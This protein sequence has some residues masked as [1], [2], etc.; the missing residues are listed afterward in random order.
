M[1][2]D[3]LLGAYRRLRL[4]REFEERTRLEFQTGQIAGF[5]HL[6]AGMEAIAV[7]VCEHLSDEDKI[8]STHRGHGHCLAKGCDPAAMMLE[9][10]GS[11]DGLCRGKGGTMHIAD[12]S[13]GML[14]ANAV[15]GA[16]API[17]V[18]AALAAS[19]TGASWVAVSFFGDGATNIGSVYEAM[20]LAVV[21][22][23]P[24][25]FVIEDNGWGEMTPIANATGNHDLAA[26]AAA[27]TK[28]SA[29]PSER[30]W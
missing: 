13:R 19:M 15:V 20:N 30:S 6:Y 10:W 11:T 26:R 29:S 14:G 4:L 16:G 27:R 2:H 24:K 3:D 22:K 23:L 25:I 18:G 12:F 17:A 7:G 21:L 1:D 8:I 28:P 9:L 5:T